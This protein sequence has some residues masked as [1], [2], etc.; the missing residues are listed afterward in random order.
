RYLPALVSHIRDSLLVQ[1]VTGRDY[2]A[3]MH[4][5][6]FATAEA[7]GPA[8]FFEEG[9][10]EEVLDQVLGGEKPLL[11]P[12]T[13]KVS[14]GRSLP[15]PG[16]GDGVAQFH[17]DDLC[18][19]PLAA[20]DYLILAA[21]FHTLFVHDIPRLTLEEHNE[22]RRFTNLVDALYEHSVR[23]ICHSCGRI[24]EVLR[25]I[26]VL[27]KASQDYA[28]FVHPVLKS[29]PIPVPQSVRSLGRFRSVSDCWFEG[30]WDRSDT[31][32]SENSGLPLLGKI[33]ARVA[34]LV[35]R[36]YISNMMAGVVLIDALLTA[37]DIDARAAER[38]SPPIVGTLSE[39]CLYC[40]TAELLLVLTVKG[41]WALKDWMVVL[42]IV[43][44]LC[45]YV[46]LVMLRL[47]YGG[48]LADSLGTLR[49]LRLAR[50]VRLMNLLRKS[51]SLKELQKLVIMLTTCMKAL[52]WSFLFCFVIMTIWAMMIVEIV[53]PHVKEMYLTE[54][55]FADCADCLQATE[56][57]GLSLKTP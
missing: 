6:E 45:G 7:T 26:E 33:R 21:E 52:A 35:K 23:L 57:L 1:G 20:E 41:L 18:R 16:Q 5:A 55:V 25:S 11:E 29:G 2:R 34:F 36:D 43:I 24:D 47:A 54:E 49:V 8:V 40:Y 37:A 53:H 15:V 28:E 27:Q 10:F 30:L 22:A 4:R 44:V 46:E 9:G 19:K 32:L 12:G 56:S 14:W 48:D 3:A 50:I 51:R 39:L 13:V 42:D 38:A 31:K 17:F